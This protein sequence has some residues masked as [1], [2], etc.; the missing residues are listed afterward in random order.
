MEEKKDNGTTKGLIILVVV[1]FMIIAGMVGFGLSGYSEFNILQSPDTG[2][3]DKSNTDEE[4]PAKNNEDKGDKEE[5]QD[6]KENVKLPKTD[7]DSKLAAV[8]TS[9][10][11]DVVEKVMHSLVAITTEGE[12]SIVSWF[13]EQTRKTQDMGS[14][15]IVDK[16]QRS[17]YIITNNHVIDGARKLVVAFE[18]GSTAK[19]E[20]KGTAAYTDLALVEIKLDSLA[21]KTLDRIKVARLG[22]SNGIKVGQMVM[23]I[24][25][26]LGYGQSLTV[27]YVSAK[28]RVVNINDITMKLIQ[29]DAAI[30]PGNSGGALLNLNGEVV[31]I[32]SAKFSDRA[33]E[34][35]GYAIPMATVKP[36]INELKTKKNITDTER[37]YLGIYYREI[38]DASHEAFNMPY[39]LYITDVADNGGAKKAGLIKG[40]I[41]VAVNDNETLKADAINSIILGKKKG[42]QVKV[43][44]CR[45]ENGEYVKKD[46]NVTLAERP[47]TN[48]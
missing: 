45:Y 20:V 42:E 40:D 47:K 15:V 7:T 5:H 33:V 21:K 31:G 9:D 14:G 46:V 19:G 41:I 22:D 35:M 13:G 1:F 39:G 6:R 16:D 2:V 8:R 36:L 11:S 44:F 28:D 26:A 37:G 18:D 4:K 23:A 3:S 48:N 32:N 27:G 43:T 10:L 12:E 25:N 30:N 29:T 34:G 17:L 38:D 24:G